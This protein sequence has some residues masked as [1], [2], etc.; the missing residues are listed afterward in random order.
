MI[1]LYNNL[2]IYILSYVFIVN[3]SGKKMYFGKLFTF[4][5]F[6]DIKRW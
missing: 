1:F 5:Y 6:S 4:L 3:M 2:E